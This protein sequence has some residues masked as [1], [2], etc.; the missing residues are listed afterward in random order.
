MEFKL[1]GSLFE[2]AFLLEL[3]LVPLEVLDHEVLTREFVVVPVVVHLLVLLQVE[4]V[5]NFVD[6]VSFHPEEVP[7]L[8]VMV[9]L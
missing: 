9:R 3:L 2:L 7:V 5:Q 1:R 6:A 4:V 8:P